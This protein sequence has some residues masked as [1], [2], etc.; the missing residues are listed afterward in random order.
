M[1]FLSSSFL[2]FFLSS[3]SEDL[4]LSHTTV[5]LLLHG[6]SFPSL[7]KTDQVGDSP[8]LPS[9]LV[10]NEFNDLSPKCQGED[11]N[12][13]DGCGLENVLVAYGHDEYLYNVLLNS[14][15]VD[16]PDEALYIVRF[17]SLYPWHTG[18]EYERIQS[19]H[20]KKMK[21]R[22]LEFNQYDLYTKRNTP[23]TDEEIADMKKHY[24]A[25]VTKFAPD[26]LIF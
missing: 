13:P 20:D 10:H 5:F 21:A 23:F 4:F 14:P 3:S 18:G 17:H 7:S 15:G 26:G 9:C 19:D 1:F 24:D 22:V 6:P 2:P 12:Y 11:C 8:T 25:L 16:L